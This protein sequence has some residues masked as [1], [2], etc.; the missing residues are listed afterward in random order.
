MFTEVH[1]LVD[2]EYYIGWLRSHGLVWF[3]VEEVGSDV[4]T[5]KLLQPVWRDD[6]NARATRLVFEDARAL[7]TAVLTDSSWWAH[8]QQ[9]QEASAPS[10]TI[11]YDQIGWSTPQPWMA[12]R[13]EP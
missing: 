5:A 13:L 12:E 6:G 7:A 11:R 9:V 10:T 8:I 1:G 3:R 4:F 2:D